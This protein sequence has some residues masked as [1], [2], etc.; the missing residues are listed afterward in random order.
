M[1]DDQ[2]LRQHWQQLAEQLGLEPSASPIP[3]EKTPT[4][5]QSPPAR[6]DERESKIEER[7]SL[8]EPPATKEEEPIRESPSNALD[9]GPSMPSP[10]GRAEEFGRE[11][12]FQKE[13]RGGRR[14]R[15]RPDREDRSSRPRRGGRSWIREEDPVPAEEPT[16]PF[17]DEEIRDV[18][19]SVDEP[20][21]AILHDSSAPEPEKEEE[22]GGDDV[23][24]L[25]D[26]NVP[27]WSELIGSLYR[28]ER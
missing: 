5:P 16:E 22:D 21:L 11:E 17:T 18:A 3:E 12:P 26:W 24:T 13:R 25:S 6:I 19:E 15:G 9:S 14:G 8:V 2:D 28:P 23:D 7:P 1:T 4:R 20:E 10:E 27:S